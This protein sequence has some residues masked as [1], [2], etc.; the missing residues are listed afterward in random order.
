[1]HLRRVVLL[2]IPVLRCTRI[3]PHETEKDQKADQA[4]WAGKHGQEEKIRDWGEEG[5]GLGE[6]GRK[7]GE[8]RRCFGGIQ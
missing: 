4:E 6:V 8:K 1:M 3:R 7:D 5:E 2:W